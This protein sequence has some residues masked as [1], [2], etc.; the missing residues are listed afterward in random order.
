MQRDMSYDLDATFALRDAGEVQNLPAPR[1]KILRTPGLS[2]VFAPNEMT[3]IRDTQGDVPAPDLADDGTAKPSY[4]VV[5]PGLGNVNLLH[6]GIAAGAVA[7]LFMAFGG[8]K[9]TA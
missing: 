1:T 9:K 6:V 7:L 3:R 2:P 4:V 8:K 5:V